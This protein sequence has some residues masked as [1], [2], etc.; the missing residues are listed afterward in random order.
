[1]ANL[2]FYK[3]SKNGIFYLTSSRSGGVVELDMEWL[4]G[5]G[6]WDNDRIDLIYLKGDTKSLL[7]AN[8]RS[9][10]R[11][12]SNKSTS[13]K[14]WF[15]SAKAVKC[16]LLDGGVADDSKPSSSVFLIAESFKET[17]SRLRALE[18]SGIATGDVMEAV[19]IGGIIL[20]LTGLELR[21]VFACVW[22]FW[23]VELDRRLDA[24]STLETEAG[25]AVQFAACVPL[26]GDPP[27]VLAGT[28]AKL[29]LLLC[30]L[31]TI[32]SFV[33]GPMLTLNFLSL[34]FLRGEF[35]ILLERA[36][37][38]LVDGLF[39]RRFVF[40]S[41][42]LVGSSAFLFLRVASNGFS[43]GWRRTPNSCIRYSLWSCCVAIPARSATPPNLLEARCTKP[44]LSA[45]LVSMS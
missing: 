23:G 17:I 4:L 22:T 35:D 42:A 25:T 2:K 11:K 10:C 3:D 32:S 43:V 16:F 5:V 27:A 29:P 37:G 21:G 26:T 1:M 39:F 38:G 6:G 9:F 20:G 41:A 28:A 8:S 13:S 45:F 24:A 33:P 15:R 18:T 12:K 40:E 7:S 36:L 19:L 34:S 44:L 31:L 14:S 30:R